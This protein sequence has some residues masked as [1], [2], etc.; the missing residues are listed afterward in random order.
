MIKENNFFV[1]DLNK[2]VIIGASPNIDKILKINSSLKL[3]T[4]IVTSFNQKNYYNKNNEIHTFKKLTDSKFEK[5]I[6]KNC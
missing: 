3:K 4:L 6:K 2:V 5:F 1:K